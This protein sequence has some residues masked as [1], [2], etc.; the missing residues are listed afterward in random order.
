[1]TEADLAAFDAWLDD[2]APP[3]AGESTAGDL[4]TRLADAGERFEGVAAIHPHLVRLVASDSVL[5]AIT[6]YAD[7]VEVQLL[8]IERDLGADAD[9]AIV[10]R[11]LAVRVVGEGGLPGGALQGLAAQIVYQVGRQ[12]FSLECHVQGGDAR[13]LVLAY[14]RALVYFPGR[15]FPRVRTALAGD[16]QLRVG[17]HAFEASVVDVGYGGAGC[18]VADEVREGETVELAGRWSGMAVEVEAVVANVRRAPDG[19]WRVGLRFTSTEPMV[20][21]VVRDLMAAG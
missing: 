10:A 9:E 18:L 7:P 13:R 5:L 14:P 12:I 21:R 15:A 19:R 17:G 4:F 1:M 11:Q 6:G 2:I 8:A 16:T 3:D 20:M